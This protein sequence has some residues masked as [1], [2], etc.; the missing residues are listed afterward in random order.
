[1]RWTALDKEGQRTE[2][3]VPDVGVTPDQFRDWL[4]RKGYTNIG[5]TGT[6]ANG[7][8]PHPDDV[9]RLDH[10]R[11]PPAGSP[12]PGAPTCAARC[13]T[14]SGNHPFDPSPVTDDERNEWE[15]CDRPEGD[16]VHDPSD[17]D[18]VEEP[19]AATSNA[20]EPAP[21][22]RRKPVTPP[23]ARTTPPD[24]YANLTDAQRKLLDDVEARAGY[25]GTPERD[26]LDRAKGTP[27]DKA[28]V[29]EALGG[30]DAGDR[31]RNRDERIAE[32]A[33]AREAA[34]AAYKAGDL[35]YP[36]Y[37]DRMDQ[38]AAND[39]P[40]NTLDVEDRIRDAYG[41]L[42]ERPG[43]PV[44]MADLRAELADVPRAVLDHA[45]DNIGAHGDT[46]LDPTVGHRKPTQEE[47]DAALNF[48]G[49]PNY[50]VRI[51]GENRG[52]DDLVQHIDSR[53]KA[54]ADSVLHAVPDDTLPAVA[55]RMGVDHTDNPPAEILRNRI[56][57][58]AATNHETSLAKG[59]AVEADGTLLYQAEQDLADVQHWDED[60]RDAVRETAERRTGW[61]WEPG[62]KRAERVLAAVRAADLNDAVDVYRDMVN[63]YDAPDM[64]SEGRAEIN[65]AAENL[66]AAYSATFGDQL[67]PEK[68]VEQQVAAYRDAKRHLAS[69][70]EGT[71]A[72]VREQ[73]WTAVADAEDRLADL[74]QLG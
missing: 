25:E 45:L 35:D 9:D 5:I 4:A 1:M 23:G 53:T 13:L 7:T 56:A 73:A 31:Y 74:A 37:L 44:S 68:P 2:G 64:S 11:R 42:A 57:D 3:T 6:P 60:R 27:E 8:R 24:P 40:E 55:D 18:D 10:P 26:V 59:R 67:D 69:L 30:P 12:P 49:E 63:E 65:H 48:G 46:H 20:G 39:Q 32:Q 52:I 43:D 51:G 15:F 22:G 70:P 16:P 19:P 28:A 61:D 21:T 58:H 33:A 62:A 54:D 34:R 41:R 29:A 47:R 38:I 72:D 14:Y 71:P 66:A 17:T 36:A 50:A